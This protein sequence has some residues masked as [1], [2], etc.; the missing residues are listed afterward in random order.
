MNVK[1]VL[2]FVS[3]TVIGGVTGMFAAKKVLLRQ[4]DEELNLVR[5]HYSDKIDELKQKIEDLEVQ[6]ATFTPAVPAELIQESKPKS[7]S[8]A[9]TA[10]EKAEKPEKEEKTAVDYTK[11]YD[12]TTKE[13]PKTQKKASSKKKEREKD[14]FI[15]E[16][17]EF[18][19]SSNHYEKIRL[20][21][22]EDED[23][24]IDEDGEIFKDGLV[25]LGGEEHLERFGE[26]EADMIYVR[27]KSTETDYA[28]CYEMRTSV[29][30]LAE[31]F[32][33]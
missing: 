23:L 21:Y 16:P 13:E 33:A 6:T 9:K 2:A 25:V 18:H 24:F 28:V 10:S 8:K 7:K 14:I 11:M 19:D 4:C 17:D 26:F 30:Y 32:G 1:I 12:T 29:Q 3:G 22:F 5:E 31:E 20:A 27:N 15:I